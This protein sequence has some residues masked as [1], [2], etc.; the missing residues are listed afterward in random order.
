MKK[1]FTL[2]TV[3][4]MAL[5]ANATDLL[6]TAKHVS[7]EEGGIQISAAQFADAKAGDKIVVT[8]TG[9][10]AGIEFKVM[11]DFD[12]LPGSLQFKGIGGDGTFE[13]FLTP[14][15]VAKLKSAGL[16]IIG[17]NFT[18]TSIELLEGK[19]NVTENT[20]W[21]GYFWMDEWT[22]LELSKASFN[23][24]DWSEVEAIRFYSEAG[25]TDYVINVLT[26]WGDDGK[27]GDQNTMTMTEG[28]AELSLAGINMAAALAD[29]DRLMIQCN[30]EGGAPFNFTSVELVKKGE[31][32]ISQIVNAQ[33]ANGQSFDLQ[34]RPI[35]G[36]HNG[37]L[38]I[39]AGKVCIT[40]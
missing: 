6:T 35:T 33:S 36:N 7:W 2:T 5:A 21:T 26:K 28:Y 30:K 25:R 23:H 3:C 19:D 12:R 8:Y 38:T 11:D 18:A 1:I 9:A 10:S 31:A 27:L 4:M 24:V 17:E 29:V 40:K 20:V 16:E 34:G 15:A 13:Q 37:A 22:T 14:A 39:T 32:G